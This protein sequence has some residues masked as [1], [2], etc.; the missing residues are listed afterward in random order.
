MPKAKLL[1]E[2]VGDG[3]INS[4]DIS[5]INA[6]VTTHTQAQ[7]GPQGPTGPQGATGPQGPA[8][9]DGVDG[10]TGATGPQGPV[11]ATFSYSGTTLTITT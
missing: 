11:G 4:A 8:G 2:L 9:V 1:A 10:A 3:A 5:D 7:V 6:Y